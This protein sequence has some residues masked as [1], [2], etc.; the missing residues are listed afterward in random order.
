MVSWTQVSVGPSEANANEPE[1]AAIVPADDEIEVEGIE[2]NRGGANVT[3]FLYVQVG[4]A[5]IPMILSKT[6]VMI[7]CDSR[8]LLLCVVCAGYA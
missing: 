8:F 2:G 1:L 5:G 7:F 3:E 4:K 6:H